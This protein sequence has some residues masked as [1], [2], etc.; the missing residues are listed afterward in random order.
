[1]WNVFHL[2]QSKCWLQTL[3]VPKSCIYSSRAGE[4]RD[5]VTW[6]CGQCSV[7]HWTWDL[8][9]AYYWNLFYLCLAAPLKCS[10]VFWLWCC[11]D[12]C[13]NNIRLLH[14][15]TVCC[16]FNWLLFKYLMSA[17]QLWVDQLGL[18]CDVILIKLLQG[19]FYKEKSPINLEL[20][21]QRY[22]CTLIIY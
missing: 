6:S 1:M 9:I 18:T 5:V 22:K 3:L 19:Y 12:L 21:S 17:C 16:Y 13:K 14:E 4:V 10:V 15:L 20:S 8:T 2:V 11:L 7:H